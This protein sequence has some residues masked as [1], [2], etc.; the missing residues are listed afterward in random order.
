MSNELFYSN[1][2]D[3]QLSAILNQELLLITADRAALMDH[4][5]IMLVGDISGSGSAVVKTGLAGLDGYDEMSAVAEGSSAA[6]VALTDA[7][8]SITVARQALRRQISDLAAIVN[9][10]R[11]DPA[12]LAADMVGAGRMRLMSMI[13]A[14]G[15]SFSNVVGSTGVD[16][17]VDDFFEGDILLNLA[18]VPAEGRLAMLHGRQVGD[19]RQSLRAESG[20]LQWEQATRDMINAAG[21]GLVARFLGYDIFQSSKVPTANSAADRA[22][23]MVGAGAIGKAEGSR[24][25][26]LG[27]VPGSTVAPGTKIWV[28]FE[29]DEAGA[30]T[31]VVGNYYV[32]VGIL[33]Q[34]RGV[35]VVTDA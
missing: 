30:L 3:L 4:P 23:M 20:V 18:S 19:L 17:S 25:E 24:V 11:M 2:T 5:A 29:R 27:D 22:G 33:E 26:Q 12:R 8:V 34:S 35:A 6:N 31:M 21:P 15:A 1:L 16:M 10:A 7:S 13:A 28:G 32:G 9:R 14:L